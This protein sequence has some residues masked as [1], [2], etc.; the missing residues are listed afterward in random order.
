MPIAALAAIALAA[1][2]AKNAPVNR[3]APPLVIVVST[4]PDVSPSLLAAIT[5]ETDAVFR[6][7]GVRFDWRRGGAPVDALHI[8]VTNEP[9]PG[10]DSNTP[11]G[12][13]EFEQ[14][15]PAHEIHVSYG[16]ALRFM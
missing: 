6:S 13:I 2:P 5:H 4:I 14:G 7:A 8:Y 10:R 1:W 15:V 3:T 16:N 12:W 11:L 9:G